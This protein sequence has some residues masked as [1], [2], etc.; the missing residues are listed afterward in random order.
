MS[1]IVGWG[2]QEY[3]NI[4]HELREIAKRCPHVTEEWVLDV[5]SMDVMDMRRRLIR[6]RDWHGHFSHS[7]DG[8]PE[9]RNLPGAGIDGCRSHK[10]V[11]AIVEGLLARISR[12]PAAVPAEVEAMARNLYAFARRLAAME[13]MGL[14]SEGVERAA[15]MLRSLAART[16]ELEAEA[17][18]LTRLVYVPGVTKCAK[19][20]LV[21]ISTAI[22]ANSGR[23]AAITDPQQCPNGCGPM[24]RRTERDAGSELCDRLDAVHERIAEVR[25]LLDG[26]EDINDNGGPNLV[27]QVMTIL[28][29]RQA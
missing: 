14:E 7:L 29:G 16:A 18:R 1:D 27:M 22:D 15:A 26:Q 3:L 23:F 6:T 2:R 8:I 9:I 12:A 20:S 4:V 17:A 25:E 10:E 19:C 13:E 5:A 24:W 11:R 28:N 21:L